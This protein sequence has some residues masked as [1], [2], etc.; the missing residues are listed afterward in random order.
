M[1]RMGQWSRRHRKTS[2]ASRDHA[3]HN[4]HDA[5]H[6]D[7]AHDDAAHDNAA[8]DDA[9]QSGVGESDRRGAGPAQRLA[10]I[11]RRR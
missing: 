2:A 6:D 4:T 5:S 8:H 9:S 7:A 1:R 11:A 10:W 3:S